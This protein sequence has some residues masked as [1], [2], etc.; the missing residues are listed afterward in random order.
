MGIL[1][2]PL[3]AEGGE[4][5]SLEGCVRQRIIKGR[6]EVHP[7]EQ[8]TG[9]FSLRHCHLEG[10]GDA[11]HL[12]SGFLV[13][14]PVDA[15]PFLKVRLKMLLAYNPQD[16]RLWWLCF[17]LHE[18]QQL[19]HQLLIALKVGESLDARDPVTDTLGLST[20]GEASEGAHEVSQQGIFTTIVGVRYMAEDELLEGRQVVPMRR[21]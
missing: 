17:C 9:S 13:P 21:W 3:Y 7:S 6:G 12:S 1:Q 5:L 20:G 16:T 2:E 4:L 8:A 10:E 11:I 19:T 15:V 18:G 14:E